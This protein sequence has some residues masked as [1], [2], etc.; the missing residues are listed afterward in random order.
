MSSSS[1]II[2]LITVSSFILNQR[3]DAHLYPGR[4]VREKREALGNVYKLETLKKVFRQLTSKW[5]L[6]SGYIKHRIAELKSLPKH[7][8]KRW[9]L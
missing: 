4:E 3:C 9:T 5:V 6:Q 1:I 8:K 7:H 2:I